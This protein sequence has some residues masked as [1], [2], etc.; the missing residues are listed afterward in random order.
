M[1]EAAYDEQ[2]PDTRRRL[3]QRLAQPNA[4]PQTAQ[5]STAPDTQPAPF[6][7]APPTT[8]YQQP[9][10]Y[11]PEARYKTTDQPSPMPPPTTPAAAP[12]SLEDILR[13]IDPRNWQAGL[14][15]NE[16]ALKAL[17]VTIQKKNGT[18]ISGRL[19]GSQF[20]AQGY[21][22]PHGTYGWATTGS[23]GG[24]AAPVAS[25]QFQDAIRAILLERLAKTR[26][27]VVDLNDPSI[28]APLN[29]AKD[30]ATR[31]SEQERK[32]LAERL[33]AQGGLNSNALNQGIQQSNERM[34]IGLASL[35]AQ[36][37]QA[38]YKQQADELESDLQLA[39][40]S[41]DAESARQIQRELSYLSAQV[42]RE[43]FGVQLAIDQNNRNQNTVT[44]ATG[45]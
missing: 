22:D 15:Q 7:S 26:T 11:D 4:D 3:M 45:R 23:G 24:D 42:Q 14:A 30:T 25:S 17:G 34:G 32:Q 16:A 2:D 39:I 43:G 20:G 38:A 31:Q 28:T 8:E 13:S 1:A 36:L 21:L 33:Y 5:A 19:Y 12:K 37:I 27:G 10:R 35:R 40:A 29:A 6:E 9:T 18:D 44:T 41:G